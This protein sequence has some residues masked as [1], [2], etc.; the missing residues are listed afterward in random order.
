MHAWTSVHS[1]VPGFWERI[2]TRSAA[3]KGSTRTLNLRARALCRFGNPGYA[4]RGRLWSSGYRHQPGPTG[5]IWGTELCTVC[6]AP[7]TSQFFPP[8]RSLVLRSFVPFHLESDMEFYTLI[9]S[10]V[11]N[12]SRFD[13]LFLREQN[14]RGREKR[15]K[16]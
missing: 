8:A 10:T 15:A 2:Q 12:V 13:L 11:Q 9:Q 16:N 4:S 14:S 6:P 3:C 1:G 7:L 5:A